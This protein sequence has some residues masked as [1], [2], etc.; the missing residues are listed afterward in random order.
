MKTTWNPKTNEFNIEGISNRDF[1]SLLYGLSEAKSAA[2]RRISE[3][4]DIKDLVSDIIDDD[5]AIISDSERLIGEL[6]VYE[7]TEG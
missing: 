4:D 7:I 3:L 2:L 1:Y 5:R 6:R